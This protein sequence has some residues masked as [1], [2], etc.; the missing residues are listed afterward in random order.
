LVE[1]HQGM[2]GG[3]WVVVAALISV[4]LELCRRVIFGKKA[5]EAHFEQGDNRNQAPLMNSHGATATINSP[6]SESRTAG[7]DFQDQSGNHGLTLNGDVYGDL[8]FREDRIGTEEEA[9]GP[10]VIDAT[11]SDSALPREQEFFCGELTLTCQHYG[12][13][14][15]GKADY[16]QAES[17]RASSGRQAAVCYVRVFNPV[18][19]IL[20]GANA[21]CARLLK[22]EIKKLEVWVR[23]G[24]NAESVHVIVLS[25][26]RIL[27]PLFTS[28][29]TV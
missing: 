12:G 14:F 6:N 2:A 22:R 26:E 28:R 21:P 9:L 23:D 7:H 24:H 15:S 1:A 18:L 10:L 20:E 3:V 27:Y 25:I 11:N 19:L 4:I 16:I 17:L 5:P 29:T 13:T 8:N